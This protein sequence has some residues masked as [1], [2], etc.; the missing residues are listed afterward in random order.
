MSFKQKDSQFFREVGDLSLTEERVWGVG[1]DS[2]SWTMKV[3]S[4]DPS[5]RS[6][7]FTIY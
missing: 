1:K 6:G 7:R 5:L 2:L 3:T 4:L